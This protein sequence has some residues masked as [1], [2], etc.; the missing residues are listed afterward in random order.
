MINVKLHEI[1]SYEFAGKCRE[2]STMYANQLAAAIPRIIPFTIFPVI[3]EIN[4]YRSVTEK[5]EQKTTDDCVGDWS[6]LEVIFSWCTAAR[7]SF[8]LK[9]SRVT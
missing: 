2:F 9:A 5:S 4:W 7:I 6:M 3:A 8:L 1:L